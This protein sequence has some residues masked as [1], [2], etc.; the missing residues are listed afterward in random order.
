[1][2]IVVPVTSKN[3]LYSKIYEH[4]GRAPYYALM[5]LDETHNVKK[6]NF[7]ENPRVMG[8]RPGIYFSQLGVEYIAIKEG[9]I[10]ARAI[11]I[12]KQRGIKILV[13]NGNNLEDILRSIKEGSL[14][15]YT[16]LGCPGKNVNTGPCG[17]SNFLIN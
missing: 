14:K 5:E 9:G 17:F 15:P 8:Y 10:G 13:A 6:I 1:L 4:F 16:G 12:L 3:G 7:I 11:E 2:K